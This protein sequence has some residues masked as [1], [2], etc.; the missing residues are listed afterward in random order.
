MPSLSGF[1]E[2]MWRRHLR[3]LTISG[4]RL[5][6][7]RRFRMRGI[8]NN[9][10]EANYESGWIMIPAP[11][12]FHLSLIEFET[13]V[14]RS[15]R[16]ITAEGDAVLNA[17]HPFVFNKPSGSTGWTRFIIVTNVKP[18]TEQ[19]CWLQSGDR[20][21][22]AGVKVIRVRM[23]VRIKACRRKWR[24]VVCCKTSNGTSSI[25]IAQDL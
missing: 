15:R 6:E 18:L 1:C 12:C 20:W 8:L 14:G 7:Q 17:G 11:K 9:G 13:T 19:R 25:D 2:W 22:S 5:A 23:D 3:T 16:N 21:T 24:S 10:G 4:S